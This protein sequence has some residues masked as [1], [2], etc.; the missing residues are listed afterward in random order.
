MVTQ[1]S[2]RDIGPV[3]DVTYKAPQL[4][5]NWLRNDLWEFIKDAGPP[6]PWFWFI[7]GFQTHRLIDLII[8]NLIIPRM[9]P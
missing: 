9:N 2:I 7:L 1:R 4:S 5:M 3:V 6:P 8:T